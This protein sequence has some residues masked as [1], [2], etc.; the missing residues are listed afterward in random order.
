M[1]IYVY[2]LVDAL[3]CRHL[4]AVTVVVCVEIVNRVASANLALP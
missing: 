4:P 3:R 2:V 1:R